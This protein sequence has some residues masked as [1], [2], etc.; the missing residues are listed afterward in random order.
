MMEIKV[1]ISDYKVVSS[2]DSLITIGLGSCVGIALYDSSTK[3][4]G[5][6]HIMLPYSSNFRDSVNKMK[7]ADTCIPLMLDEMERKGAIRRNIV[8]KIAG[9]SNMF[10]MNGETIGIKNA[11]AVEEVLNSLRIPIKAKDCGGN[12]GRTVRVDASTGNV[13]VKKIG[14]LEELLK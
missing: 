8:A 10:S 6:A 3:I 12:T 5:L 2:P 9:G 1:N 7:F 13:F 11:L 4:A 14:S